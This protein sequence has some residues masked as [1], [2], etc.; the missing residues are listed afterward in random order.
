LAIGY[1]NDELVGIANGL[2][3]LCEPHLSQANTLRYGQQQSNTT[4]F[5]LIII[6]SESTSGDAIRW[7]ETN[8]DPNKRFLLYSSKP[9]VGKVPYAKLGHTDELKNAAR[10]LLA[11]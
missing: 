1:D 3:S 9:Y 6:N 10:G 4:N 5:D 8:R 7:A 2:A 11:R